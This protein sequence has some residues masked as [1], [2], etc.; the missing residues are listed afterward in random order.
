MRSRRKSLL[1]PLAATVTGALMFTFAVP[2]GAQE[3]EAN[4]IRALVGVLGGVVEIPNTPHQEQP[5]GGTSTVASLPGAVAPAAT[6]NVLTATADATGSSASVANV[7]AV[8][9]IVPLVPSVLTADAITSECSGFDASSAIVNGQ[10][11]GAI[12]LDAAAPPNTTIPI[13]GVGSVVLNEQ[14]ADSSGVTVRAV[15]LNVNVAGI[16]VAELVISE[17][18]CF[19]GIEALA[20]E[21]TAGDPNLTG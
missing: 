6:A 2:A 18:A 21:A 1:A 4:G 19:A 16:V 17:S 12:P 7:S 9:G 20:A 5:P 11:V 13:P 10:A 3:G 14:I 8:N 15:H